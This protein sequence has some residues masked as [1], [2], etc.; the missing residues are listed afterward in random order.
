MTTVKFKGETIHLAGKLPA[1][2][3]IA[4]SF[5]L[6]G[7][8]L[9]E[10]GL[11]KFKQNKKLL[12]IYPSMDTSVCSMSIHKFY[13]ACQKIP[14]LTVINISMD[15]PFAAARYCTHEKL[16]NIITLSAFR[17]SF[18][19]DYGLKITDGP[20]KG[21][22][23]RAVIILSENN[24]VEYIELVPEITQEPNYQAAIESVLGSKVR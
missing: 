16:E 21:L 24:E 4:P 8:D 14:N 20:I 7:K 10:I 22:L 23:A 3:S 12:N 13:D 6:T 18:G 5:N 15:L 2:K 17:S 1:L 19:N 11:E 9:S